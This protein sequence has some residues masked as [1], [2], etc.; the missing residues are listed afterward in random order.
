ML[1]L[2]DTDIDPESPSYKDLGFDL[3][4]VNSVS[5]TSNHCKAPKSA[6]KE[7]RTDGNN[8]IDNMFSKKIITTLAGLAGDMLAGAS[9][10]I[11]KGQFS[12]VFEINGL[13]G[14]A[15]Y[16]RLAAKNVWRSWPDGC[17]RAN[18]GG[19]RFCDLRVGTPLTRRGKAFRSRRVT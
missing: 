12:I 1:H 3:D 13:G 6:Q 18:P 15:N 2:G 14:G 17:V 10:G 9:D 16:E 4:G 19:Y 8:G 11:S 7:V 5:T